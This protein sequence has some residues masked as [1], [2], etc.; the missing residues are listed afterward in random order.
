MKRWQCRSLD[1]GGTME[2]DDNG[3]YVR[4]EDVAAAQKCFAQL[5]DMF[6]TYIRR[7]SDAGSWWNDRYAFETMKAV[8]VMEKSERA[9]L[10]CPETNVACTY[11]QCGVFGCAKQP[12]RMSLAAELATYLPDLTGKV[13]LPAD[14]V[15]RIKGS[16]KEGS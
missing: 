5:V 11:H 16:L 14:L 2:A 4:H 6:K 15:D 10:I 8:E 13:R 12:P 9:L 7:R 1:G 3:D